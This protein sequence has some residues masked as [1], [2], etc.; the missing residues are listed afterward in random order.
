MAKHCITLDV[1]VRDERE[2][3]SVQK[4]L[5]HLLSLNGAAGVLNLYEELKNNLL[6][7]TLVAATAKK[8]RKN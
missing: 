2:A 4:S 3:A 7:R 6:V 8:V 1:D 5:E